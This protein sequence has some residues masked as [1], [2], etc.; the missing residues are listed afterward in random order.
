M[1]LLKRINKILWP[2]ARAGILIF[3]SIA[4]STGLANAFEELT[5]AQTLIYDKDHLSGTSKGQTLDYQYISKDHD[6]PE[7]DDSASVS[8]LAAHDNGLR[9]VKVDFLS[10]ERRLPLPTFSEFRGNPVIIA[11][12]EHIAQNMSSHSGGGAL[13]FRN[14]I[15]DALASED[16]ELEKSSAEYNNDEYETTR[17]TFYPFVNDTHLRADDLIRESRFSIELS[18]DIPGSVLSVA[19]SA[20]R[21]S[22]IFERELSLK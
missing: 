10:D 4:L 15:R 18:D 14:R 21:D 8:I 2:L 22:E 20:Q 5:Q 3:L 12:L 11:M 13:Y 1:Q 6:L 19:V 9:D 16:I 7:I 17:I